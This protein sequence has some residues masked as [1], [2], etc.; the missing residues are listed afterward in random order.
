MADGPEIVVA[1]VNIPKCLSCGADVRTVPRFYIID[2]T[3][4]ICSNCLH[5]PEIIFLYTRLLSAGQLIP[6]DVKR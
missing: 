2:N 1:K 6:D 5:K 3:D 4:Y